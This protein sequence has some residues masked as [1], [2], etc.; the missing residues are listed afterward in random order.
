M[1]KQM[2][3]KALLI[4]LFFVTCCSRRVRAAETPD[5]VGAGASN[6]LAA[7]ASDRSGVSGDYP[8]PLAPFNERMFRFNLKLDEYVLRPVAGGYA[9]AV[10]NPARQSVGRFFDNLGVLPRFASDVFQMKVGRAGGEVARFGI[11]TTLGA[12]GLFDVADSWFGLKERDNDF[13][14]TLAHYGVGSGPYLVLPFLGPSTVRD[15]VGFA[16]DGAMNPLNYL[17]PFYVS[18]A[19]ESGSYAAEAVNYRSLHLNLFEEADRYAIDLYG[20]V[21]D[22]YLE[23]RRHQIAADT[24]EDAR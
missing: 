10:P 16:A 23:S 19:A 2:F 18:A 6:G 14:L 7:P 1:A 3:V 4:G 22:A 21:Q 24:V 8:D 5:D 13:G 20:A 9:W 11:N 15:T 12:A 17:V